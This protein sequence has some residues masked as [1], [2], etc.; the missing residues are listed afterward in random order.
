MRMEDASRA[1][2][3]ARV[4]EKGC[5][6]SRASGRCRL[7]PTIHQPGSS[8]ACTPTTL[9]R[10]TASSICTKNIAGASRSGAT[11]HAGTSPSPS[12]REV[13]LQPVWA[14]RVLV[15]GRGMEGETRSAEA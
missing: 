3:V 2:G 13:L 15:L 8:R 5:S 12:R 1:S 10:P 11:H 6:C 14:R 4:I 7:G 9:V